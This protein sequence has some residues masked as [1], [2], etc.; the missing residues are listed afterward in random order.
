MLVLINSTTKPDLKTPQV[1][2]LWVKRF[3]ILS[4]MNIKLDFLTK[5]GQVQG[6]IQLYNG[7]KTIISEF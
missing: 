7:V 5:P 1:A 3:D 2:I 6:E 4:N